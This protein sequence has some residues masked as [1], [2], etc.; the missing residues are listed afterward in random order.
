MNYFLFQISALYSQ[1]Y[2]LPTNYPTQPVN[3]HYRGSHRRRDD[4]LGIRNGDDEDDR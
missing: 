1:H 4:G 2:P 3:F